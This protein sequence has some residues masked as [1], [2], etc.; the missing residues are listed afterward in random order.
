MSRF[1]PDA[2]GGS[3]CQ[4]FLPLT[5][6]DFGHYRRSGIEAKSGSKAVKNDGWEKVDVGI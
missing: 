5:K 6:L 1:K 4:L 3:P 2:L